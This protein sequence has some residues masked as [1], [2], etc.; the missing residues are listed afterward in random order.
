MSLLWTVFVGENTL[1]VHFERWILTPGRSITYPFWFTLAYQSQGCRKRTAERDLALHG[2]FVSQMSP[3]VPLQ[4][5]MHASLQGVG[6]SASAGRDAFAMPK[7]LQT[8]TMMHVAFILGILIA[9]L[10]SSDLE[11]DDGVTFQ[12]DDR[13]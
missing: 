8:H 2:A 3:F 6:G 4:Y 13:R 11:R 9:S 10:G 5:S 12:D 1:S 7:I